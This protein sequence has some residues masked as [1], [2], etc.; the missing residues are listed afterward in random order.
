MV[1]FPVK[2]RRFLPTRLYCIL[3]ATPT[4]LDC[5]KREK[6]L[7]VAVIT[8]IPADLHSASF[9]LC[10]NPEADVCKL[11]LMK[12]ADRVQI[13]VD[14]VSPLCVLRAH[15]AH[16]LS[17]AAGPFWSSC[18]SSLRRFHLHDDNDQ[19]Q[20]QLQR[21]SQTVKSHQV[22]HCFPGNYQSTKGLSTTKIKCNFTGKCLKKNRLQI[23][24][25]KEYLLQSRF[26]TII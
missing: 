7:T 23:W 13:H 10:Q 11:H 18:W 1:W 3:D 16:P 8:T 21:R 4:E 15:S 25:T 9:L 17:E 26:P 24:N 12:P 14:S 5:A 19:Q 22:L 20:L 2:L 6:D